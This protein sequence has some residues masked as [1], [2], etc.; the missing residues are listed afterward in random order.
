LTTEGSLR[1]DAFALQSLK[2][3]QGGKLIQWA[4]VSRGLTSMEQIAEWHHD[5]NM[6]AAKASFEQTRG[7][8]ATLYSLDEIPSVEPTGEEDIV[9]AAE[10]TTLKGEL[11]QFWA[12]NDY[13]NPTAE[14]IALPSWFQLP[15]DNVLL[16][17]K[18]ELSVWEERI[19][20]RKAN[21]FGSL[22]PKMNEAYQQWVSNP[23]RV[24][25]LDK[26]RKAQV[27]QPG[28]KSQAQLKKTCLMLVIH[29]SLDPADLWVKSG[30]G[31][32]WSLHLLEGEAIPQVEVPDDVDH[33]S[34]SVLLVCV[35]SCFFPTHTP[36][37]QCV[38][39]YILCASS[40]CTQDLTWNIM[41]CIH[42]QILW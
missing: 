34:G 42:K 1:A 2:N 39:N 23:T 32:Q 10:T 5:G 25:V 4:W 14:P 24:L 31:K 11:H 8:M 18:R 36:H 29:P 26:A 9:A 22:A 19:A 21:G 40:W 17:W 30:N 35:G 27:M 38:L 3:Y 15:I 12:I 16:T 20:K 13:E 33:F 6:E 37:Q 41:R 7:A 28:K